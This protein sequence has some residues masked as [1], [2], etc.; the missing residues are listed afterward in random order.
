MHSIPC[1]YKNDIG[2][3]Y[4]TV[5][6]QSYVNSSTSSSLLLALNATQGL[7]LVEFIPGQLN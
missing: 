4:I 6:F 3:N 2:I 1:S 7:T 5:V